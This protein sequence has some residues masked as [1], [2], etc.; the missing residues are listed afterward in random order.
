MAWPSMAASLA[1]RYYVILFMSPDAAADTCSL[2]FLLLL[3]R[4]ERK[5]KDGTF[6]R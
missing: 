2:H 3:H 5:K 6:Q 1:K 4:K